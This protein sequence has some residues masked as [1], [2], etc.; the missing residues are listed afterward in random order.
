MLWVYLDM[1]KQYYITRT[2]E[3]TYSVYAK[4]EQEAIHK[5]PIKR[6]RYDPLKTVI[7]K[8]EAIEANKNNI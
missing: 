3:E 4:S 5:L 1:E 8:Q 2:I 6:E 7:I